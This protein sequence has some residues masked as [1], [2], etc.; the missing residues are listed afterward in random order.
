MTEGPL[1]WYL[2]RSTGIVSSSCSTLTTVLGVLARRPARRAA[3]PGSSP[4]PCTATSRCSR[5]CCC[6][7]FVSAVVDEFVDIRWW[8]AFVP[9]G[10]S[11]EPLWLG[12]GAV[13]L[14]LL[15]VIV[16][17]QPV[18]HPDAA[19]HLAGAAPA[20]LAV[21]GLSIAHG[22]GMGTDL[23]DGWW[24]VT[25]LRRGCAAAVGWRLGRLLLD[26]R[27]APDR[28]PNPIR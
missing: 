25:G 26:R 7:A 14:D 17:Y 22:I 6:R 1:L 23:P 19:P 10:A 4:R 27:A 18:A 20:R 21:W 9:F 15:V 12:L 16:V 8:Q 13:A 11:Y 24:L 5:S 3:C 28:Q 2:N